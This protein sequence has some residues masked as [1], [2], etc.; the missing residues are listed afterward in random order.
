MTLLCF[1]P[2][3]RWGISNIIHVDYFDV[4]LTPSG[5]K[6]QRH[7]ELRDGFKKSSLGNGSVEGFRI[8]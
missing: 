7:K 5:F 6:A 1:L 4:F 2:T 8:P 3:D